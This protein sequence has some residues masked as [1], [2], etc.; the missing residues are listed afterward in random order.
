[1]RMVPI[2]AFAVLC[3][4]LTS[5]GLSAQQ[6]DH[7]S[8][9]SI[10]ITN[11]NC[12]DYTWGY[13]E[14]QTRQ[15]FADIVR[16]HL[17]EMNRTDHEKPE[18]RDRYNMAV[19]Q[20]AICFVEHYPDRKEELIR[21]IKEGR[22]FVSPFLCNSLWGFQ[23]VEGV[24]RTLYPARCLEREWGIRMDVAEHIEEPSLPWGIASILAGCG[25]RWLS[26][27]FYKYDSTFDRLR[28]A[29]L[30]LFEGP[31]GSRL[32]VIMDPWASGR[33]SYVQGAHLLRNTAAIAGEWAPHYK[34]LG[35]AYP[36]RAILASGT[37]GDISPGSGGQAR[38]FAEAIIKY[39]DTPGDHPKLVNA[40]LPQFCEAADR[41]QAETPFLP[42]YRGC[43]GHSW[44]V[45]PVSLAKY[46]ADMRGGERAFLSAEA[47]LSVAMIGKPEIHEATRRDRE[48]AEWCWAMLSDHAWNGTDDRN[49]RHN[50][51]LRKQWSEELNALSEKLT[52]H[53]W[54]AL[55]LAQSDHDVT[56]FN[57][58]SFPRADLVR[59]EFPSSSATL[60]A[61]LRELNCQ[62]VEEDGRRFLYFVSHKIPAFALQRLPLDSLPRTLEGSV[63]LRA[64]PLELE[65]PFYRVKVDVKTGG[66]ASLIHK[67]SGAEVVKFE[68]NRTLCQT[69]YSN[70]EEHTLQDVRTEV[71]SVGPVLARLDVSGKVAGIQVNNF[72]TVYSD[73]DRV[74][75]ELRITKP[76]TTRQER[77][78]H[79]FPVLRDDAV[80]RIET[81]GAV[82]RPRP[83][84]E[85]DL[86]PG[87]DTRRFAVRGF[88]DV[89]LPEGPGITIAP[90]DAFVL[91]M[92][93]DLITFEALGNDQNYREVMKDQHGVTEFRF[94][95]AL[96]A[97][98]MDYDGANAALWSR[99]VA[100]PLLARWGRP[101]REVKR[102]ISV[103]PAR[104][105]AT[106]LKPAD[107]RAFPGCILRLWETAGHSGPLTVE[108]PAFRRAVRTDLLERDLDELSVV[109]GKVT[110]DL[111]GHGF[112]AVRLLP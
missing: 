109:D 111:R 74:D 86:L 80:L 44:D 83:Q 55:G 2:S 64:T 50:A 58:L 106:C 96:R 1:M 41:V 60:E 32:R 46:V 75:F 70:N 99:S 97:H 11:D 61:S 100:F 94:R 13:T 27:P 22:V 81:T 25:I 91:R 104:A 89:S 65:S 108:A 63:P 47:L 84:P 59:I 8:R 29:P 38:G 48:R 36:L 39:N 52:R 14:Q 112:A 69:V 85:G 9:W 68:G 93:L 107:G 4:F 98:T 31:D 37:H 76:T 51:D 5:R 77:M 67:P 57:P 53:A 49:K 24:L 95:Y 34:Q 15:A 40:I 7:V 90:L 19:T 23:S 43:F 42:V 78:C 12:P 33:A 87:A 66:V 28:N 30:F 62:T 18:N 54:D 72:V 3:L 20:E 26:N 17:D 101:E 103:D 21:R 105:I 88:V 10:Y 73:L 35:D 92:D 16:A 82:I 71:V 6:P 102:F 45:W 79:I 56:V 110:L